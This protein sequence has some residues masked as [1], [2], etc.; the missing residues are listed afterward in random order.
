VANTEI[1]WTQAV[2]NPVRGCQRVSPGCGGGMKG[3]DG[4]QGGCYAETMAARIVRMGGYEWI[5]RAWREDY[6]KKTTP[7]ARSSADKYRDL[8]RI[9]R[10][11]KAQWTGVF[12]FDAEKLSEPLRRK[13][14][15]MYFVNSMSDLFGEGLTD[16]QIAAVFGV[17]AACPQ[18]T[19]QVLT[20]RADRTVEWF[21]WVDDYVGSHGGS[22]GGLAGFCA[23]VAARAHRSGRPGALDAERFD[24]AM[25]EIHT[26][27]KPTPQ[28]PLPNVWLGV[29]CERQKEADE[30]IPLLLQCPAAVRWVSAEPL[31]GPINLRRVGT[32]AMPLDALTGAWAIPH[33][34]PHYRADY[35]QDPRL[36]WIVF[37]GESGHGARPCDVE[38]LR[39]GVRQCQAAGVPAFVKQLGTYPTLCG[40]R[41]TYDTEA[42]EWGAGSL[43]DKKGADPAEW[44]EDLRVREWPHGFTPPKPKALPVVQ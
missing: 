35:R 7:A 36:S 11:G 2:W 9:N 31:L 25:E 10:H 29:S 33:D 5:D 24:E 39:D 17:M 8:V 1:A 12:A 26:C 22:P 40:A 13:A 14:P 34:S 3:P 4:E 15:T 19:F 44:P 37:G 43:K 18:H 21:K 38:W 42:A 32:G 30:R 20:K 23:D 41:V 16:H 27:N 28:W 6:K